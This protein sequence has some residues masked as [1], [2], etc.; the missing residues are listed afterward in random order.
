MSLKQIILFVLII[1]FVCNCKKSSTKS[2][3]EYSSFFGTWT[4]T[5]ISENGDAFEEYRQD[6]FPILF[7]FFDG[8]IVIDWGT[9]VHWGGGTTYKGVFS[10]DKNPNP[11]ELDIE[12]EEI[13]PWRH[14]PILCI[15]KFE[16]SYTLIIKMN[17]STNARAQNFTLDNKYDI[18]KLKKLLN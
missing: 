17:E 13:T 18:Y 16:N 9:Q 14:N 1:L 5:E 2:D 3:G 6:H 7:N 12:L 8:N 10:I 4:L 11:N 15:Y